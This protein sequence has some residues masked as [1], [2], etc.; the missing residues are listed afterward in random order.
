MLLIFVKKIKEA[1]N[2]ISFIFKPEIPF[3]WKS[4][5]FLHYT[6]PHR[7]ADDRGIERY[8]TIASA[9]FEGIVLIT[10]RLA[11]EKSSSFKKTLN[12]LKAGDTIEAVGPDGEFTVDNINQEMIFIAG[13]IGIT[14]FRS[15]LLDFEHKKVSPKVTLLYSN[16]T[17]DFPY[18]KLLEGLT[19]TNPNLKIHYFVHPKRIDESSFKK[20]V[21][22]LNKPIFYVSG[23]GG[24]VKNLTNLLIEIGVPSDHIRKDLFPGYD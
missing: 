12:S 5:Q 18:K 2:T 24:M 8:F 13:G 20:I 19:K 6:L 3:K 22:N 23:P 10:T 17:E 16:K 1:K 9:P 15:M 7:N 11:E 14:P 4:G 21:K